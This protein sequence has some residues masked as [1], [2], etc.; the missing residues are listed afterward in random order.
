[1]NIYE[2]IKEAKKITDWQEELEESKNK[3]YLSKSKIIAKGLCSCHDYN[4]GFFAL[5]IKM[6]GSKKTGLYM[7]SVSYSS[8]DDNGGYGSIDNIDFTDAK[9]IFDKIFDIYKDLNSLPA[10]EEI[11]AKFDKLGLFEIKFY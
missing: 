9:Y 10:D 1:M 11:Q 4:Y 6:L 5:Q 7:V 2:R 3:Y 8:M